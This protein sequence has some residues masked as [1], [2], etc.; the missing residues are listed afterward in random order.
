METNTPSP[1]K[2]ELRYLSLLSESYPTVQSL[3]TKIASLEALLALPKGTEHFISDLHGEYEAVEH[4]LNNCSGV[5]REKAAALLNSELTESELD[6]LCAVIYYPHQKLKLL[7]KENRTDDAW[8]RRTLV[9]LIRLARLMSSKYTREKVRRALPEGY[10]FVLDELL[11]AQDDEEQNRRVYH[12]RIVDTLMAMDAQRELIQALSFLIKSLAVDRLHVLGDLFDRGGAPDK[13]LDMLM[14]HPSVDFTWGNHDALWMGAA[15]G[16]K[17]CQAAAVRNSLNYGHTRLLESGYGISLRPL[18]DLAQKNYPALSPDEAA[19]KTIT[20]L[21]FK[22]EGQ[23]IERHPEYGMDDRRY[24]H[25][26]DK[27][28]ARVTIDTKSWPLIYQSFPTLDPEAPYRLSEGEEQLT[29]ALKAAFERSEKLHRHV[30][31]LYDRG[32]LYRLYNGNLLLHG[33]IPLDQ[34]SEV[35]QVT[36]DG[37]TYSGRSFLDYCDQK[38]RIAYLNRKEA[39]TDFLWFLWCGD[40]SPLCGRKMGTFAHLMIADKAAWHEPRDPYYVF[41]REEKV[42]KRL[43]ASFGLDPE[44]GRIINGHTPVLKGES[45]VRAGGKLL[46]IDGG[47]CKAYQSKTGIAGYTLISNSHGMRLVAHQPFA[48]VQEAVRTNSDIPSTRALWLPF[49]KRFM[50]EDTDEGQKI[51]ERAQSLKKLLAAYRSG[52]LAARYYDTEESRE[53]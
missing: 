47:F 8:Y 33:C 48:G 23:L 10:A 41:S 45:P 6:E 5:I 53:Y 30:R 27:K 34:T 7:D 11:N 28:T 2:D 52:T 13:I 35:R 46:V 29:S 26:I 50:V 49:E 44:A 1:A 37:Q 16:C 39:D 25:L 19:L 14:R 3:Y 40:F 15:A 17:V 21:M 32:G 12:Q 31:F 9:A 4:I 51:K 24:L 22:L 42:C 43:L 20:V 36:M 18:Y 38:A